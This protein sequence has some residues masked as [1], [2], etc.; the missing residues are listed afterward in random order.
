MYLPCSHIVDRGSCL[1]IPLLTVTL[2]SPMDGV[3]KVSA[4]HHD[5]AVYNGPFAKIYTGDAHVRIE[6]NEEQ[7][8]YQTGSVIMPA[9]SRNRVIDGKYKS[10]F[11][12]KFFSPAA[13]ACSA[14]LLL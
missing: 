12:Q 11:L 6:E 9:V 8:I 10:C 3:I 2:S 5:G 1:N 4:V 7:L 14:P 13:S